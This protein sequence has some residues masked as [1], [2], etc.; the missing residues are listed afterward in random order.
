MESVV[1]KWRY[2]GGLKA[3]TNWKYRS[4]LKNLYNKIGFKFKKS[5]DYIL[6]KG[7][8]SE[9]TP[10]MDIKNLKLKTIIM[11]DGFCYFHST[12]NYSDSEVE[13]VE[14]YV[15]TSFEKNSPNNYIPNLFNLF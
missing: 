7:K 6:V 8:Y 12:G 11:K 2:R 15:Y 3:A 9:L 1:L 13:R 14:T 5:N 4:S 10:A